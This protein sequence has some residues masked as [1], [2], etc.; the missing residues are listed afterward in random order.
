MFFDPKRVGDFEL[1]RKRGGHLLSKSRYAAAQLL[2]YIESG[3]WRRNAERTNELARR[4]GAAAAARLLAPVEAN[5]VF[6]RAR[7]MRASAHCAQAGFE[8]YDWGAERSGAARFVVSWDQRRRGGDR[9]LRGARGSARAAQPAVIRASSA[10]PALKSGRDEQRPL[11]R[12]AGGGGIAAL[13]LAARRDS[14]SPRPDPTRARAPRP[15]APPRTRP[16]PRRNS[17]ARLGFGRIAP[18]RADARRSSQPSSNRAR[19]L[20][21]SSFSAR[22]SWVRPRG[23]ANG[24][25]SGFKSASEPRQAPCSASASAQSARTCS[26]CSRLARCNVR[27]GARPALHPSAP[28][29]ATAIVGERGVVVLQR[30]DAAS[31]RSSCAARSASARGPRYS[32]RTGSA[33][34]CRANVHRQPPA[35][36]PTEDAH[37]M[38]ASCARRAVLRGIGKVGDRMVNHTTG[39]EVPRCSAVR[40]GGPDRHRHQSRARQLRCGS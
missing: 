16:R 11:E 1:R 32:S 30:L 4:I 31:F 35:L 33:P 9:A 2:A 22:A 7:A 27:A 26:A 28:R 5:E 36:P 24:A 15:A 39:A 14:C 12:I 38:H 37:A 13:E 6:V 10:G 25:R 17:Q 40:A 8:F 3:L 21:G 23:P 34:R 18:L 29:S 19:G 20:C